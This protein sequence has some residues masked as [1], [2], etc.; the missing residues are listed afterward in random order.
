MIR[1]MKCIT[2]LLCSSIILC[3]FGCAEQNP[4][5]DAQPI[6]YKE[7]CVITK[8]VLAKGGVLIHKGVT[9]VVAKDCYIKFL[10]YK[11]NLIIHGKLIMIG[12]EYCKTYLIDCAGIYGNG[13]IYANNAVLRFCDW[14]LNSE[15]DENA[16]FSL[17]MRHVID[18]RE[19]EA[20]NVE[21]EFTFSKER[22]NYGLHRGLLSSRAV[23][24]KDCSFKVSY[25]HDH[26]TDKS[27]RWVVR[28]YDGAIFSYEMVRGKGT[29]DNC[30][31][32]NVSTAQIARG[33]VSFN[34][35]YFSSCS[36]KEGEY[37]NVDRGIPTC[38]KC[39]FYDAFIGYQIAEYNECVFENGEVFIHMK[40]NQR[41][42]I[43]RSVFYRTKL[44]VSEI[45][46]ER[47]C[48]PGEIDDCTFI[49]CSYDICKLSEYCRSCV[50]FE[51]NTED[52]KSYYGS[53]NSLCRVIKD[54]WKWY[55][56]CDY[57]PSEQ[58]KYEMI[59]WMWENVGRKINK[60]DVY[61]FID[62]KN[63]YVEQICLR[64]RKMESDIQCD[65][66]TIVSRH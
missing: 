25:L 50:F 10:S 6:E 51:F 38:Y 23:N 2:I 52:E 55:H 31:F 45:D 3:A 33:N 46:K 44:S 49:V 18:I 57:Q 35:C 42:G 28:C 36:Y 63:D 56:Y 32:R 19:I 12:D 65:T 53:T 13:S 11:A 58:N 4:A 16:P 43:R 29:M 27:K 47:V 14:G 20:I 62:T 41:N 40:S 9:V 48:V 34:N 30:L 22:T 61:R 21:Y 7:D 59:F 60:L 24:M 26:M 15:N 39:K 64:R 37:Y 5:D 17:L 1:I 66:L 54:E 8:P